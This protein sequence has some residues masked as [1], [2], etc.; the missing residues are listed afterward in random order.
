M[1]RDAEAKV[2]TLGIRTIQDIN[3]V[4]ETLS[5]GQRQA[6]AVARAVA[7]GGKVIVLDEPTAALG[8]RETRQVLDIVQQL[9]TRALASS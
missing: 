1:R 9:R 4:V 3:Q 6:V 8:V 5:G 7:F 2:A